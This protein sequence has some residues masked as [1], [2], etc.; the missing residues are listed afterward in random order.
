MR[1]LLGLIATVG[2]ALVL[3]VGAAA[4]AEEPTGREEMRTEKQ[5]QALLQA[6]RDLANNRIDVRVSDG[7]A[8]LTGTVDSDGER[9][10]AVRLAAVPGIRVVDD[11]LKVESAGL[12]ATVSDGTITTK[13][14]AQFFAN[15]GLRGADISV[16]T[17][18]GV[19]TL[20]GTAP[21]D[22]LRALAV[23]LARHTGGVVRVEDRIRVLGGTPLAP[24][25]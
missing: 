6:D 7:V 3:V 25:R 11:Q 13:I 9:S 5:I 16:S 1:R 17:N 2:V 21:T 20:T 12:K 8:A 23:D 15:T 22:E 18:N 14:K 24:T 4:R 10:R 19:V